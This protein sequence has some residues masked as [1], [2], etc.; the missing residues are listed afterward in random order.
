LRNYCPLPSVV[1]NLI[2]NCAQG[3]WL[4]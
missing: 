2:L 1:V 3:C 4:L